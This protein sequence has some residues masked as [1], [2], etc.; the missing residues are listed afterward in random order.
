MQQP[1]AFSVLDRFINTPGPAAS[2]FHQSLQAVSNAGGR[3]PT[4]PDYGPFNT[5]RGMQAHWVGD[6]TNASGRGGRYWPYLDQLDIQKM[7]TDALYRSVGIALGPPR[8]THVTVWM[9]HGPVPQ[10]PVS[11]GDQALLFRVEVHEAADTV[12]LVIITPPLPS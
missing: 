9:P 10:T 8:K 2:G 5:N 7:L 6:W 1:D 12:Q 3:M 11:A 4:A